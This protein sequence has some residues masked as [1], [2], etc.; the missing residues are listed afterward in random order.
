VA[1]LQRSM[2]R[3]GN[4]D[5][6]PAQIGG[7]FLSASSITPQSDGAKR[8]RT[9]RRH[10]QTVAGPCHPDPTQRERARVGR[11][12]LDPANSTI[13]VTTESR[14][15]LLSRSVTRVMTA[16]MLRQIPTSTTPPCADVQRVTAMCGARAAPRMLA[17]LSLMPE[18]AYRTFVAN[19][20]GDSATI[21]PKVLGSKGLPALDAAA[22]PVVA[23]LAVVPNV[24]VNI[25]IKENRTQGASTAADAKTRKS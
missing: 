19:S 8:R 24:S 5:V 14:D 20:S 18:P 25:V 17:R 22:A 9:Q 6:I 1:D 11:A 3:Q 4:A 2:P 21:G 12:R 15:S 23:V 7:G 13:V 10:P 16:A